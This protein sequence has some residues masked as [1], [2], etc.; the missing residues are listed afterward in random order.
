MIWLFLVTLALI[1]VILLWY[2]LASTE[3]KK[4]Y[5]LNRVSNSKAIT[6]RESDDIDRKIEEEYARIRSSR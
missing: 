5:P 1:G 4:K 6:V 3:P 2:A